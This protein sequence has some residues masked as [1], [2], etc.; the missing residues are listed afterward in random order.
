MLGAN[1]ES[2][3]GET[4]ADTFVAGSVIFGSNDYLATIRAMRAALA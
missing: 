1:E 2:T 4:G 3:L